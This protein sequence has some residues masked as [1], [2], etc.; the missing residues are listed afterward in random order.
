M[1][2]AFV[3]RARNMFGPLKGDVRERLEAVIANPTEETWD[4]A[5]SIILNGKL[6]TLWQAWIA[7]DANAP[8]TGK[9][10]DQHGKVIQNWQRV[11]DQLTL[12]RAIKHATQGAA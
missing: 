6:M 10:T 11:P 9:R 2:T 12:Y 1:K 8:R 4:D 3:A 5:F 7:V